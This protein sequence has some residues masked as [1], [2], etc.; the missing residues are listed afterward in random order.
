MTSFSIQNFG[1]RVNQAE[2]FAWTDDFEQHGLKFEKDF[3]RSD[4]VLVNTCTL[5]SRAERDV[6]KFLRKVSRSNPRA[7]LIIS[8]CSVERIS[9]ELRANSQVWCLFSNDEK[10]NLAEKVLSS[11][12]SREKAQVLPFRSRAL[13]KIQEGCNFH[14][15]F[16]VIPLVRGKSVSTKKEEIL[17]QLKKYINRGFRE[18]VLTGIHLCSYGQDLRPRTSLLSLLQEIEKLEGLG[19]VRLSSLDP[20]FLSEP[21]LEH[22]VHSKKICPHFHLSLQ[23]GCDRVLERMGRKQKVEDYERFL[24]YLH[25]NSPSASLGADIIVGFPGESEE[26]FK[27]AFEFLE[28]MPLTY[29]HVFSYSARPGTA[30][31]AWPQVEEKIK[32]QRGALLRELSA[33]KNL[34][35]RMGYEGKVCEAIFVEKENG[36]SKVLTSNYIK[37]L[38]PS[39]SKREG[40]EVRV[41]ISKASARATFGQIAE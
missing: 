17:N 15:T 14:C 37:V 18:I 13:L 2:A 28:K 10:K 36:R 3:R 16:C 6:R 7:R 39:C 23:H 31:S 33:Q 41:R 35:F 21:L 12:G 32:A 19:R 11:F 29:F 40:E 5:T 26:D 22:L 38:V 1:C 34:S 27:L 25:Q 8:G 20:R 24:T 9:E 30:A 4:L